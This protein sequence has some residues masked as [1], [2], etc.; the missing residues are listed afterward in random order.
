MSSEEEIEDFG[1]NIPRETI[2]ALK[3][4]GLTRYE[5]KVY[6]T[7]LLENL[8]DAKEISAKTDI[9]YSRIYEV[10]NSLHKKGFIAKAEGRPGKFFANLPTE[11]INKFKEI[12]DR[13]FE[14][15]SKIVIEKL[16]PLVDKS[17]A[18]RKLTL[19]L[20]NG[21]EIIRT[22]LREILIGSKK[23]LYLALSRE[24]LS[25]IPDLPEIIKNLKMLSVSIKAIALLSCINEPAII[26]ISKMVEVRYK[27]QFFGTIV[28][29]DGEVLLG[30]SSGTGEAIYGIL[31][32][33]RELTSIGEA[34]FLQNWEG[35]IS[36]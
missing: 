6:L 25:I 28:I 33:N 3:N 15:N 21:K 35:A 29:S 23:Y 30:V 24:V 36:L 11:A 9:P 16:L 7:L 2:D 5:I 20:L 31:N 34:Y 8:L 22:K 13:K 19:F 10:L 1:E 4:L 32:T 18:Q 12:N 17:I 27:Q 26:E 14:M